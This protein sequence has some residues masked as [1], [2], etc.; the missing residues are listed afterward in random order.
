MTTKLDIRPFWD[1]SYGIYVVT[2]LKGNDYNAQI[3]NTVTQITQY[4]PLISISVNKHSLTHEYIKFSNVFG[5]ST[6]EKDCPL[7]FI[8][9]IGFQSGRDVNKL[10]NLNYEIGENTCPLITDNCLS[11]IEAEVINSIDVDTHTLFIGK[12]TASK[13]LKEGEPMTFTHYSKLSNNRVSERSPIPSLKYSNS[14]YVKHGNICK[15]AN[16]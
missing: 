2:S 16:Q 6:V 12:A 13:Y 1:L 7:E 15:P 3:S 14:V 9:L 11:Y 10:E 4:S 5:V 8:D